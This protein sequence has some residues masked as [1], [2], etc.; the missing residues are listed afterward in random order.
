MEWLHETFG[1]RNVVKRLFFYIKHRMRRF[2][3][4]F[5]WNA[6][7][8][9]V[10]RWLA[11]FIVNLYDR[12][13]KKLTSLKVDIFDPKI[14]VLYRSAL[15]EHMKGVKGKPPVMLFV[16]LAVALFAIVQLGSYVKT[17]GGIIPKPNVSQSQ[18]KEVKNEKRPS[19]FGSPSLSGSLLKSVL[20]V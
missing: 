11:S 1:K 12:K 7:Y 18:E 14:F 17:H 8:E 4:R 19:F 9:T 13:P 3:K 10:Y 5:P 2:Y 15:V 6:K 16:A 20:N